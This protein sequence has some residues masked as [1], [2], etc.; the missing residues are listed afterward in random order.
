ME[1]VYLQSFVCESCGW[2]FGALAQ[3]T[4]P[5]CEKGMQAIA[6]TRRKKLCGHED[7][8]QCTLRCFASAEEGEGS[9]KRA[10]A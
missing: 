1:S 7:H 9:R 3:P 5:R 6:G 10:A 2:Q 8:A 4:C